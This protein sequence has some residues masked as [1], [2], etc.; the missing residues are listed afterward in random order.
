MSA[1][2]KK[3]NNEDHN[4]SALLLPKII[5]NKGSVSGFNLNQS[6]REGEPYK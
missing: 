2:D 4:N 6:K 3:K 5:F 1:F